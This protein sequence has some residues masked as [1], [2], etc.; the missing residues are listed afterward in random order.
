MSEQ[1]SITTQNTYDWEG[2]LMHSDYTTMLFIQELM[3]KGEF[4]A[5]REG[6]DKL[7]EFE[8][9]HEKM[10]MLQ[11]LTRL[12]EAILLWKENPEYQTSE[13]VEEIQNAFDAVEYYVLEGTELTYNYYK[14]IWDKAYQRAK[15]YAEI[16]LGREI[17]RDKLTWKEVFEDEYSMFNVTS[18]EHE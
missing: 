1:E 8:T 18:Q 17:N 10:E 14:T 16:W 2:M 4:E 7:V 5:A 3:H 13:Q 15:E 12:M 6:M 9:K 11:A